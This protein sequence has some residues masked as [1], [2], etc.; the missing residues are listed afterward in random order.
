MY[1]LTHYLIPSETTD[2]QRNLTKQPNNPQIHAKLYFKLYSP[3][4]NKTILKR[5]HN[6]IGKQ[7][8]THTH[9]HNSHE[10]GCNFKKKTMRESDVEA[11]KIL[12]NE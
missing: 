12:E 5:H 10:K 9:T 1:N 4:K 7:T 3:K 2:K 8:H 6:P 11:A